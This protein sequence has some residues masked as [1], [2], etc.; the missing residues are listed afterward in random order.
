MPYYKRTS[1]IDAVQFFEK[2]YLTNKEMYLDVRDRAT[3]SSLWANKTASDGRFYIPR[4]KNNF[5][6][7]EYVIVYEGDYIVQEESGNIYTL[8]SA[9]FENNFKLATK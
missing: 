9:V 7:T 4:E 5:F 6:S 1:L 3:F 8:P 2:E